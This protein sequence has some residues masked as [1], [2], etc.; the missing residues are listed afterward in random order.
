MIK[1]RLIA[2]TYL[3]ANLLEVDNLSEKYDVKRRTLLLDYLGIDTSIDNP[4]DSDSMAFNTQLDLARTELKSNPSVPRAL[5]ALKLKTPLLYINRL[6]DF[7]QENSGNIETEEEQAD[8]SE[9]LAKFYSNLDELR[10]R[11]YENR[12]DLN[13]LNELLSTGNVNSEKEQNLPTEESVVKEELN[14]QAC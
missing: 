14:E 3:S 11:I 9:K 8:E 7:V 1:N 12:S 2:L 10:L 5:V 13:A 6:F 4:I